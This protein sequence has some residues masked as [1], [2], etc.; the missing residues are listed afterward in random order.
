MEELTISNNPRVTGNLPEL[1]T[2]T[3]DYYANL[4]S[5]AFSANSLTGTFPSSY[6]KIP[7][8]RY[9]DV[10]KNF[11]NGSI[12]ELVPN[13]AQPNDWRFLYLSGNRM[14][15]T[16]P[17]SMSYME[18]LRELDIQYNRFRGTLPDW[19]GDF[20]HLQVLSVAW[21]AFSG[22][23]PSS[24]FNERPSAVESRYKLHD[25][26][27]RWNYLTGTIPSN[28]CNATH[29][30]TLSLEFNSMNGTVPECIGNVLELSEIG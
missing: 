17:N 25:F 13:S 8:L 5:I 20:S 21:N 14:T 22:T 26:V 1:P 18:S 7:K 16:L 12:P 15:G 24:L 27:A 19:L 3:P 4:K 6:Y 2:E 11:L 23:I 9:V 28:I 30:D 10:R 29:L